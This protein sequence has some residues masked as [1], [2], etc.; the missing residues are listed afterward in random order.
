MCSSFDT[1]VA[2]GL[3]LRDD[4]LPLS[5]RRFWVQQREELAGIRE[6]VRESRHGMILF[7]LIFLIRGTNHN[8]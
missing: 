7:I 8:G 3:P 1:P 4:D 5:V 6:R 2:H